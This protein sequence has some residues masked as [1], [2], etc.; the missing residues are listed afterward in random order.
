MPVFVCV[1]RVRAVHAI[2]CK[3]CI[4]GNSRLCQVPAHVGEVW[5]GREDGPRGHERSIIFHMAGYASGTVS[6]GHMV[7]AGLRGHERD[8]F[9]FASGS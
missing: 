3:A 9:F 2:V 5:Q 8:I 1:L 6:C 4:G 7:K